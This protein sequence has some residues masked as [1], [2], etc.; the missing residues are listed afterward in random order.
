MSNELELMERSNAVIETRRANYA[1]I[2]PFPNADG[3]KNEVILK[4]DLDFGVIP[5]T[6]RP[7][8]FKSGAERICQAY[9]VFA[10]YE[11]KSAIE[12]IEPEPFFY[13]SYECRLVKI[14]ANGQEYVLANGYG[15]ANTKESSN[16][17]NSGFNAA[18]NAEKKAQKRALVAAAIS[19]GGLSSM[20]YADLDD[21][22]FANK[23]YDEIKLTA[24]DEAPVTTKQIKRLYAIGNEAGKNVQDI[25]NLLAAKG[26]TST[27]DIKQKDYDSVIKL[28]GGEDVE[29]KEADTNAKKD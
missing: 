19:L 8:L 22:A 7:T 11:R 3:S 5:K 29:G 23:G 1:V 2:S 16:G 4:R 26:Y 25:K 10:R 21:S 9:G 20:F 6:V 24:D 15:N 27:K 13:Y 28:V 17:F 12:E 14:G 18:N